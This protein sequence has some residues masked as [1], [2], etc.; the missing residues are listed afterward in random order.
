[1]RHLHAL[2]ALLLTLVLAGCTLALPNGQHLVVQFRVAIEALPETASPTPAAA[3]PPTVRPTP[4]PQPTRGRVVTLE[5]G[6][7]GSLTITEPGLTV[8]GQPGAVIVATGWVAVQIKADNVILEGLTIEGGRFGVFITGARGVVVQNCDISGASW[9]GVMV[10]SDDGP[11]HANT[12][13]AC[14][15]HNN[16]HEG[17]YVKGNCRGNVIEHN[18]VYQNG[19]EGIQNTHDSHGDV[20]ADTIIRYNQVHDNTGDWGGGMDLGG[21][22][23]GGTRMVGVIVEHNT[24]TDNAGKI[25]GIWY[26][27]AQGGAIRNNIVTGR[28]TFPRYGLV[29]QQVSNVQV[30]GNTVNG[31][32][33]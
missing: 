6:T 17:I 9:A 18:D 23:K 30:E 27:E 28:G 29:V 1:M 7:H 19:D 22:E 31:R 12:I 21:M 16:T 20:P 5:P 11:A 10:C 24:V 3:V 4:T 26:A 15:V 33:Q 32:A 13:R 8:R 14:K 25:A 2:G